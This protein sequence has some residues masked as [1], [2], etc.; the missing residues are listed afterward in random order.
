MNPSTI[1]KLVIRISVATGRRN[2]A[3][4]GAVPPDGGSFARQFG[5]VCLIVINDISS[6]VSS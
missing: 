3:F 5:M 4:G 1:G 2:F 6:P